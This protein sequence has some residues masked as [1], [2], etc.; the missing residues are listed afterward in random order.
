MIADYQL[1][2]IA[3][4]LRHH[5]YEEAQRLALAA[6][7]AAQLALG[8]IERPTHFDVPDRRED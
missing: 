2:S 1:R 8:W 7:D 5:Q 3:L 4:L 6:S